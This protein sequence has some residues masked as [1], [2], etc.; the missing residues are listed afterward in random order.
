MQRQIYCIVK[1]YYNYFH[2]FNMFTLNS[3]DDLLN[4]QH[5]RP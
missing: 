1:H 4:N 3:F 5:Q 2:C